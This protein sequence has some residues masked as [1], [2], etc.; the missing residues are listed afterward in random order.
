MITAKKRGMAMTKKYVLAAIN[1]SIAVIAI[2]FFILGLL[3]VQLYT[4]IKTILIIIGL[5]LT[6]IFS[7]YSYF[8]KNIKIYNI[9][10]FITFLLNIILIYNVIDLNTKY[11]YLTNIIN[12]QYQYVKYDVYVQKKNVIYSDI[13]KLDG[14]KI[15][16]LQE[17]SQNI[18]NYINT[19]INIE[20]KS[21][22]T[23]NDLSYAIENGEIQSFILTEEQYNNINEEETDIKNKIRNI[24]TTKIK[25]TKEN[26]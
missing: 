11:S 22:E 20:C 5:L 18:S 16:T 1:I 8:N 13:N 15:G 6:T 3:Q 9:G 12:P 25:E 23:I 14:K 26:D 4:P 7:I 2:V 17:N 19:V 10:I 21:Y 24:Y